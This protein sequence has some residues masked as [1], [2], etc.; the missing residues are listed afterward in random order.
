[1]LYI[2]R[3]RLEMV[4]ASKIQAL[5]SNVLM[6]LVFLSQVK[7]HPELET[8]HKNRKT[9]LI[10]QKSLNECPP[11]NKDTLVVI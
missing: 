2:Y 10:W 4:R 3:E 1:M 8:F 5:N 9:V 6:L 11:K 7:L